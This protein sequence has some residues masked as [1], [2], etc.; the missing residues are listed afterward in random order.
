MWVNSKSFSNSL[1]KNIKSEGKNDNLYWGN[2]L[3]YS[4]R[5]PVM[6]YN[7]RDQLSH[8]GSLHVYMNRF[9]C[10]RWQN[11]FVFFLNHLSK[12]LLLI[13]FQSK[14]AQ[15]IVWFDCLVFYTAF[16]NWLNCMVHVYSCCYSLFKYLEHS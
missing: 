4:Q 3:H 11:L 13:R 10:S 9:H 14:L 2:E 5:E 6:L 7:P 12:R 16:S 8:A 1:V 15:I